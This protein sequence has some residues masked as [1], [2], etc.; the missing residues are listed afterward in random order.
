M[1]CPGAILNFRALLWCFPPLGTC[2]RQECQVSCAGQLTGIAADRDSQEKAELFWSWKVDQCNSDRQQ[3]IRK[4]CQNSS[5]CA[6]LKIFR[7]NESRLNCCCCCCIAGT[8][9]SLFA[10]PLAFREAFGSSSQPYASGGRQ[11]RPFWSVRLGSRRSARIS[12]TYS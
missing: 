11:Y 2:T 3:H 8:P 12:H 9:P 10:N 5:K 4:R 7:K 1:I 6:L